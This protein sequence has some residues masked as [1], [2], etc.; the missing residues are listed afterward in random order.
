V[1]GDEFLSA[2]EARLQK[3]ISTALAH[4]RC[5]EHSAMQVSRLRFLNKKRAK[6][7]DG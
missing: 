6:S 7:T 4:L 3:H 1:S 2:F 5:N